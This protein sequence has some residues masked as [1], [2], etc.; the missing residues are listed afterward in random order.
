VAITRRFRPDIVHTHTAKAGFLGRFAAAMS[1]R[2]RPIIVHTYH[3]HVLEGYFGKITS[4]VFRY[5][6]RAGGML[7]DRLIAVSQ[8][9]AEDLIRMRVAPAD[10]FR[11]IR[12][13]LPIEPFLDLSARPSELPSERSEDQPLTATYVGRLVPIKRVDV[14]LRAVAMARSHGTSIRLKIVG[15]G[16]LREELAA[17]ASTLGIAEAVDFLGYQ[18]DLVKVSRE[19]DIG[20]LTSDNEGTPVSLIEMAAAGR[21]LVATKVGGVSEVVPEGTGLLAPA[22]DAGVVAG[23]LVKLASSSELRR[24]LGARA[25]EHD[26]DSYRIERLLTDIDQLYTE[27]LLARPYAD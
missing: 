25:R 10:K 17:L 1:G 27:L 7:S 22:G 18:R 23:H 5:L 3:G 4:E 19:S 8:P 21:P 15:D 9:T 16:P 24:Q 12:L 20:I 26:R 14:M 13:G 6:E 2:R 11:V